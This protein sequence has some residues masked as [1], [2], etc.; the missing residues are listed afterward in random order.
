[1]QPTQST[2]FPNYY[3]QQLSVDYTS[4]Q[5][6]ALQQNVAYL[7]S[8]ITAMKMQMREVMDILKKR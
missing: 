8:E 5:I 4:Q 1:M 7:N 6:D 3:Y 2:Y